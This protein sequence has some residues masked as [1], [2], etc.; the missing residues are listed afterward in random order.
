MTT[1]SRLLHSW[2]EEQP[3]WPLGGSLGVIRHEKGLQGSAQ[4]GNEGILV[5]EADLTLGGVQ[6]HIH[7]VAWQLQVLPR[8]I[9]HRRCGSA[10]RG[11]HGPGLRGHASWVTH[12][13]ELAKQGCHLTWAYILC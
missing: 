8:S 13:F 4:A 6:V 2:F 11:P 9:T 3:G 5:Q 7:M 1:G 10:F 12:H